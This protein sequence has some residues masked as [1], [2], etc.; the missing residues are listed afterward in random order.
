MLAGK[1]ALEVCLDEADNWAENCGL[2]AG[3]FRK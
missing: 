1:P 2:A 3:R